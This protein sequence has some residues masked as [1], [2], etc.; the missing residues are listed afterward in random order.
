[1]QVILTQILLKSMIII[2]TQAVTAYSISFLSANQRS[3]ASR[4][5]NFRQLGKV[6][7]E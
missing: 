7:L 6:S 3:A 5:N 2:N 4:V 1:M